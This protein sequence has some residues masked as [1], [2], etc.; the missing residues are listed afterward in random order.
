MIEHENKFDG[1]TRVFTKNVAKKMIIETLQK[2]Y[3]VLLIIDID[4]FKGCNDTYGH[5]YGDEVLVKVANALKSSFRMDDIIGRFGGD[6]FVVF[7]KNTSAHEVQG[8]VEAYQEELKRIFADRP[9]T[10]SIGIAEAR[11][12][13]SYD[14][15]LKNA[16]HALYYS[17][18][19][20]RNQYH[21]Y[22]YKKA[23]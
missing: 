4:H 13:I 11:E 21:M 10:C 9:V 1:L 16:D 12:G 17:K 7:M 8:K 3:G 15:L 19:N 23:S 14:T 5:L 6:E 22:T 20:G 2:Q 18:E